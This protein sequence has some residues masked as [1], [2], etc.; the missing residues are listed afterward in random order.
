MKILSVLNH[1]SIQPLAGFHLSKD[2]D[3]LLVVYPHQPLGDVTQY[4]WS[5]DVPDSKRLQLVSSSWYGPTSRLT[6][7]LDY[8][9]DRGFAISS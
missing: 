4:L 8:R 9:Y 3:E 5:K 1:P 2:L 7:L 6:S